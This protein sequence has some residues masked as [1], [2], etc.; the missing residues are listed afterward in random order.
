MTVGIYLDQIN[1]I[2]PASTAK[3]INRQYVHGLCIMNNAAVHRMGNSS[4]AV[5]FP[6]RVRLYGTTALNVIRKE[7][8]DGRNPRRELRVQREIANQF[9]IG[10]GGWLKCIDLTVLS[11]PGKS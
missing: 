3:L 11:A 8:L 9:S 4:R 2:Q 6:A 5:N 7:G 1:P 10:I